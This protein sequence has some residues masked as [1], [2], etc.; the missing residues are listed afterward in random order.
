MLNELQ[1]LKLLLEIDDD[2]QDEKLE[3]ILDTM[4]SRL[5]AKIGEEEIPIRLAFIIVEAAFARYN[6]IGNEGM[7][8]FGSS[9]DNIKF[10]DEFEAYEQ[11]IK[12]YLASKNNTQQ[13]GWSFL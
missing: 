13:G 7:E 12:D 4:R 8:S 2:T 1:N 11:E 10:K 3:Y 5:K 9:G 6:R